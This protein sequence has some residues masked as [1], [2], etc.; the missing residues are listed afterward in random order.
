MIEAYIHVFT[1]GLFWVVLGTAVGIF[2]GS[3]PGLS[4]AMIISLA[5]PMT[6]FMTGQDALL[7]LVSMYIGATTGGL[8]SAMLM[9]MPG[10]EAA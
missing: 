10:T 2:I 9:K 4:G 5:L 6:Y 8:L 3:I 1:T 7:L